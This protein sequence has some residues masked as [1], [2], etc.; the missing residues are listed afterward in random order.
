MK[1]FRSTLYMERVYSTRQRKVISDPN[2]YL[3]AQGVYRTKIKPED[4][5]EWYVQGRVYSGYGYISAKGVKHLV[6]S[7][8][9]LCPDHLFKDDYL[10]ISYDREIKEKKTEGSSFG[11]YE[12]HDHVLRGW[13]VVHFLEA[14]KKYSDIDTTLVEAEI[15]KKKAWHIEHNPPEGRHEA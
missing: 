14:V 12:G 6:Y 1:R 13:M 9:Y 3:L 10:F 4:L 11:W 2:G 8:C 5:P 7:P 15:E